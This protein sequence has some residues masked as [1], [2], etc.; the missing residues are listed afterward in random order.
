MNF[1]RSFTSYTHSNTYIYTYTSH[2]HQACTVSVPVI[3][4]SASSPY[5][6]PPRHH[7]DPYLSHRFQANPCPCTG[8]FTSSSS[9]LRSTVVTSDATPRTAFPWRTYGT[10]LKTSGHLLRRPS[11]SNVLDFNAAPPSPETTELP[12]TLPVDAP[13]SLLS[14]PFRSPSTRVTDDVGIEGQSFEH[15]VD[16]RF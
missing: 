5:S 16:F 14:L 12:P 10:R 15:E 8:F 1:Q 4:T 11:S 2:P 13:R 9:A 7:V 3:A 6:M